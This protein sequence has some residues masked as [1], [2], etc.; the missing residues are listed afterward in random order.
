MDLIA[1]GLADSG[2]S[3]LIRAL[4]TVYE[5][6]PDDEDFQEL[7]K[8]FMSV[9]VIVAPIFSLSFLHIKLV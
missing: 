8:A 3:R 6:A 2:T 9:Q 1:I 5:F 7:V 4:T